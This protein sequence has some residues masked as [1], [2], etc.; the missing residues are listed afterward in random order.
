MKLK[1]GQVWAY[2]KDE[3]IWYLKIMRDCND[4]WDTFN[5]EK[6]DLKTGYKRPVQVCPSNLLENDRWELLDATKVCELFEKNEAIEREMLQRA[7]KELEE[8]KKKLKE[9]EQR[10]FDKN[11]SKMHEQLAQTLSENKKLKDDLLC[12]TNRSGILVFL[13]DDSERLIKGGVRHAFD[14]INS[15]FYVMDKDDETIAGFESDLVQGFMPVN[16]RQ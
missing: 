14:G 8:L 6:C 12:S 16:R 3:Y 10:L 5:C 13:K 7:K 4:C 2:R 9:A 1:V 15:M 11:V